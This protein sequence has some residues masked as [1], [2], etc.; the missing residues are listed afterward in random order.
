MYLTKNPVVS[1][2]YN[3]IKTAFGESGGS[4]ST[5]LG[6]GLGG[7]TDNASTLQPYQTTNYIVKI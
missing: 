6:V 3:T 2:S 4:G 5:A 7:S 1:W